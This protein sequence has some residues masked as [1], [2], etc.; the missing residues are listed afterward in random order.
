MHQK[1]NG[2]IASDIDYHNPLKNNSKYLGMIPNPVVLNKLNI[3]KQPKKNTT[4]LLGINTTSYHKKGIGY[5]EMA[6]EKIKKKYPE[7]IIKKTENLPFSVY[8]KELNKTDILLDQVFG[9]DQGYNALEAMALGKVVFT[10]AEH[11]F[12]DYYGLDEDEVAI[13][14]LPDVEYLV[15]K[16]SKLIEHPKEIKRI[17][18]NAKAFVIEHHESTK[19]AKKYLSTWNKAIN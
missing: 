11:E 8:L 17:G 13:N 16:L 19:V 14:A 5:F 2:I 10:G 3:K 7:V 9:Y 6:L 15:L 18:K 4:I 1:C 12:L